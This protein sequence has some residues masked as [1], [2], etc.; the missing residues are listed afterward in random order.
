MA[1]H[2]ATCNFCWIPAQILCFLERKINMISSQI[3]CQCKSN[4]AVKLIQGTGLCLISFVYVLH[5]LLNMIISC[6]YRCARTDN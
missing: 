6:L 2:M 4:I 3:Q 5:K 1:A